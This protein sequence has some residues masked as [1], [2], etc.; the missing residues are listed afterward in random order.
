M[1]FILFCHLDF[2][3][4]FSS[5]LM[6]IYQEVG[7]NALFCDLLYWGQDLNLLREALYVIYINTGFVQLLPSI[8]L[9][10]PSFVIDTRV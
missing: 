3:A 8:P 4:N 7:L 5:T 6:E 2:L 1:G 10:T 9:C